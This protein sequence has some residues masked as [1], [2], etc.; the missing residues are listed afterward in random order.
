MEE[1]NEDRA[2]HGKKPFDGTKA[3]EEKAINEST[4]DPESGVFSQ[5]RTQEMLCIYSTDRL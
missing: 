1:I 5:R 3:T 4:T 2:D